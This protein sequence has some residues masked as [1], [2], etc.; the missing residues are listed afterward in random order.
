MSAPYIWLESSLETPRTTDFLLEKVEQVLK[1][2]DLKETSM[3]WVRLPEEKKI[4]REV[5]TWYKKVKKNQTTLC[6]LGI[7]G[8]CLGAKAVY[9]FL[10]PKK[11][12]LFFDNI[13]G[14]SFEHRLGQLDL[15]KTHFLAISKSGETSETLFQLAHILEMIAAKKIKIKDHITVIT[16]DKPSTLKMIAAD[17]NLPSLSVPLDVGGRFSVLSAVGLAPLLWAGVDVKKMLKGASWVKGEKLLIARLCD[18]YLSSFRRE[19]WI[20]IFWSYVDGLKTFGLWLEQLWAESL[21]KAK[22]R[23]GGVAPRASTPLTCIGATDQH[24]LLQQFTEGARDKSFMFLRCKESET[25]RKIK[26]I[27][28]SKLFLAKNKSVGELLGIEATATQKILNDLNLSTI[29]LVF[30]KH[31]AKTMGALIFIF[32]LLVATLGE[33]LNVNAHDQPG[34]E[35]VKRVTLGTLGDTRYKDQS[36]NKS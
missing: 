22:T 21:A 26:K 18:F 32:E 20:S 4:L 24:S 12:V 30:K 31:D 11:T 5:Q 15:K 2:S 17:L 35:A 10:Q 7:G 1:K 14:Y 8:S 34:V 9:D 25:S 29:R 16:E 28:S 36:L 33:C 3:G 13:D 23:D 19:E 6:V 27:I